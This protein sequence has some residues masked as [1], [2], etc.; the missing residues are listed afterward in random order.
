[1]TA[2]RD[3]WPIDGPPELVDLDCCV[4]AELLDFD[5]CPECGEDLA[6]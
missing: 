3:T 6:G 5:V 4:R 1:M 2:L